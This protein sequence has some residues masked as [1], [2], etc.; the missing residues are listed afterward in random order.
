MWNALTLEEGKRSSSVLQVA[1]SGR[2]KQRNGYRMGQ[3]DNI[4][5]AICKKKMKVIES[6]RKVFVYGDPEQ[7]ITGCIGHG[8]SESVAQSIYDEIVAFA[9]YA[10]NKAHAVCYAVVSYQ[11]AYLKCH[12]PRQNP[13]QRSSELPYTAGDNDISGR[14]SDR[15]PRHSTRHG[16]Y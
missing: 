8:V 13:K 10:F 12:Y 7:G 1:F 15:K 4:R 2:E 9:N 3:A 16:L 6:E 11:T 14:P 5:R